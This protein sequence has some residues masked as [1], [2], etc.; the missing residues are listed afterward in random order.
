MN[1]IGYQT[2]FVRNSKKSIGFT[3]RLNN[4]PRRS[5]K[6]AARDKSTALATFGQKYKT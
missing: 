2:L 3:L 6:L 4:F 1:A 5:A